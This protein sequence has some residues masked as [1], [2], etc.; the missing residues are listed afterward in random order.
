MQPVSETAI[1]WKALEHAIL[2]PETFDAHFRHPNKF[3]LQKYFCFQPSENHITPIHEPIYVQLEIRNPLQI[4][5]Q[6]NKVQLVCAST[7][8]GPFSPLNITR[9]GAHSTTPQKVAKKPLKSKDD[10]P[11][12]TVANFDL[13][14]G[15]SESKK[16][17]TPSIVVSYPKA[18]A[19]VLQWLL[20]VSSSISFCGLLA[21]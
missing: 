1:L 13:F 11:N 2:Y 18:H 16:V 8:S 3:R 10:A 6:L 15:P 5:L 19:E 20:S 21:P 4:P 9:P 17:D 14:L 7:P 12:I